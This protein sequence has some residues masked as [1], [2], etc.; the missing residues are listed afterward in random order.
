MELVTWNDGSV[1]T[2]NIG[3]IGESYRQ[4]KPHNIDKHIE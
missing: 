4:N 1:F 2:S 3:V